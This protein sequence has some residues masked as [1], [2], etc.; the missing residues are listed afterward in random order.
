MINPRLSDK[1]N[2]I[3]KTLTCNIFPMFRHKKPRSIL[4]FM[5]KIS[6]KLYKKYS[7][8]PI[9]HKM[10]PNMKEIKF[11]D[12]NSIIKEEFTKSLKN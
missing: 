5:N 12:Y 11:V 4:H 9:C 7:D 8:F 3:F 1:I 6:N 10:S 2:T